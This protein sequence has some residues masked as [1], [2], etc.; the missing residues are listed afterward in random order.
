MKRRWIFAGLV[1]SGLLAACAPTVMGAGG[2]G[3]TRSTDLGEVL[4]DAKDMTL[5]TYDPDKPGKSTC[6][7]FCASVWPP[8]EASKNAKPTGRFTFVT[9]DGGIKQWAYDGKPLYGYIFDSQPGDTTGEGVDAVW[10]VAK[11]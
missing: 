6:T 5:Y 2:P 9:R 4:V 11:P 3:A 1:I 7:G 8:V 10:H